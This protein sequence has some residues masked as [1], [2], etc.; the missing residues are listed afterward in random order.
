ME[1]YKGLNVRKL[2]MGN[3]TKQQL[4]LHLGLPEKH[5]YLD[6]LPVKTG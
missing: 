2:D 3:F 1:L 6:C 4:A 5:F